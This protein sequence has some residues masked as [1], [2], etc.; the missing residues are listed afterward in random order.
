MKTEIEKAEYWARV[1]SEW[2]NSGQDQ[3]SYCKREGIIFRQFKSGV[4]K[5][6]AAGLL[7]KRKPPNLEE[8]SKPC[9]DSGFKRIN[10]EPFVSGKG[11]QKPAYCEIWFEGKLGIRVETA[12]SLSRLGELIKGLVR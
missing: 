7:G 6:S 10:L 1:H 12:E 2:R 5:A 3:E 8:S 9:E 4:K 11:E